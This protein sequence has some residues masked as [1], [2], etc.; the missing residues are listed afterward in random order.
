MP[1]FFIL[2]LSYYS[3]VREDFQGGVICLFLRISAC[4][5]IVVL[6]YPGYILAREAGIQT[7][8]SCL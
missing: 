1:V 4:L 7:M 8:F 3:L 5:A 6:V 2:S